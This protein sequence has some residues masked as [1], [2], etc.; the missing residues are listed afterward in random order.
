MRTPAAPISWPTPKLFDS[1]LS[2]FESLKVHRK[3]E[4][5]TELLSQLVTIRAA[6]RKIDAW[7]VTQMSKSHL[8]GPLQFRLR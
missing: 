8:R 3:H 5:K 7:S 2:V 6:E 1:F 4:P